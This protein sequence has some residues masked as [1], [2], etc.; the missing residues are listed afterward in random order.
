MKV[1][2]CINDKESF[3]NRLGIT[4]PWLYKLMDRYDSG[5]YDKIPEKVLRELENAEN[6]YFDDS[7]IPLD[8]NLQERSEDILSKIDEIRHTLYLKEKEYEEISPK[9]KGGFVDALELLNPRLDEL[10]TEIDDL[11][12]QINDLAKEY[13]IVM[14]EK[15]RLSNTPYIGKGHVGEGEMDTYSFFDG[16][17]CMIVWSDDVRD[18]VFRLT[19]FVKLKGTYYRLKDYYPKKGENF[20]VIDDV[21]FNA[22]L[23][24][25]IDCV[26][27]KD[28]EEICG[29]MS[30]MCRLR[31]MEDSA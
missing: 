21:I 4:R 22:P 31:P 15:A 25:S 5:D 8:I 28:G 2:D 24:Y 23:Y 14:E 6:R 18:D 10:E 12:V 3:A 29:M 30:A 11:C 17:R 20:V 9:N 16:N 19:L 7:N 26:W 27:E 1:R 13:D